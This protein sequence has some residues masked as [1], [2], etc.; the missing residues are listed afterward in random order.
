LSV[1]SWFDDRLGTEIRF[2]PERILSTSTVCS[3]PLCGSHLVYDD[4]RSEAFFLV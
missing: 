1:A 3:V 4:N 2:I